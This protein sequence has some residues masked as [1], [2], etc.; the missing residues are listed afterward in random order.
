MKE[1][2][3]ETMLDYNENNL[4]ELY[5]K[6]RLALVGTLGSAAIILSNITLQTDTNLSLFMTGTVVFPS[7]FNYL[8]DVQTQINE[9]HI[10]K[11]RQI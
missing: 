3:N 4:D 9:K 6:R 7:L 10:I 8:T 5:Q 1:L 11:N 2:Q